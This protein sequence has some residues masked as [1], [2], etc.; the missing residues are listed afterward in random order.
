MWCLSGTKREKNTPG[1]GDENAD[2]GHGVYLNFFLETV[3]N[4]FT[5]FYFALG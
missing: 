1:S 3:Q 4:G 5:R 2:L